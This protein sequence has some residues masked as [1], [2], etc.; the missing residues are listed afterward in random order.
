MVKVP[1]Y[2]SQ[3]MEK[4]PWKNSQFLVKK[5]RLQMEFPSSLKSMRKNF[6]LFF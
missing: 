2:F 1:Y 4:I 5:Q 3:K 6:N